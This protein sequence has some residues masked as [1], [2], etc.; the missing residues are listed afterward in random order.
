MKHITVQD[1]K[2]KID[3]NEE[4]FVLDVREVDE[5]DQ[6]NINARLLPLSKINQMEFD[7]I[8]DWKDKEVI[9]HCKAGMRSMHACV[10]LE[11]AGFTDTSNLTG[12]I[13]AWLE[14]YPDTTL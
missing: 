10:I 5:F 14:N 6:V 9:V 11:Q 1:L 13:M 3:A 12:G 7:E 4:L 8:M 2:A